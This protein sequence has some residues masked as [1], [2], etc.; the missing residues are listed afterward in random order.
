MQKTVNL[1][2]Q[3]FHFIGIGGIGMSA[4]AQIL[5]TRKIPVSGSDL[6]KN[7]V[8]EK[9]Q[10]LG[11]T[12][13]LSQ[14]AKNL[15]QFRRS[16]TPLPQV[17]CS[18]AIKENNPEYQAALELQ[19]P[20]FH[21]SDLL[22]ALISEAPQS[23]AVAGTHGKT[24]TSSLI[25]H[26]LVKAGL[27]PTVVIGGEVATWE[28][29]ARAGKSPYLVAEADESDGS[30]IK[31]NSAFGI[32]TNIELDHPDHYT[33]LE[34]VLDIFRTFVNHTQKVLVCLDCENIRDRLI[35]NY[36]AQTFL[37]Y[38]LDNSSGADYT[39]SD[40][41]Y[42]G[43]GTTATVYE[44]GQVLGSIQLPLLGQHNLANALAAIAIGRQCGVTL[45]TLA[46]GLLSFGGT[47]RRFELRGEANQIRL[48]DDYAHHPSEIEVTLASAKLKVTDPNQNQWKRVI[49]VF[50]PH[51][52]SRIH[53]FLKEFSQAFKDAD[54]VVVTD[55]YSAGEANQVGIDAPQVQAAIAQCHP[56]VS[57]QASLDDVTTY[58]PT[59]AKPGDLI[60]FL[61]AGNLNSVIPQ[62]LAA[63]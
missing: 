19:C 23:I 54:H 62:V 38:S 16:N 8:T 27:D 49:A 12:I 51:R 41:V 60:V 25:G 9:L 50:Q 59:I 57:L 2:G 20:M 37:T 47:K 42:D 30:L 55:I 28:G 63:L 61:G 36:P 44:K 46:E 48:I 18:T 56:S 17:V 21:R 33:S 1:G 35:P 22:A 11:T 40:I 7:R 34:D 24:T 3:P 43:S 31:F 45:E 15:D 29:N 26:L 14:E 32:I 10:T 4:L 13:F 5:A 58:L 53:T 6:R 39:V 52:Y